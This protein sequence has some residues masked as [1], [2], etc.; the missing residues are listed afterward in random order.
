VSAAQTT[1]IESAIIDG[2]LIVVDENGDTDF[3]A[4]ESYVAY[5]ITSLC[6][7]SKRPH[8]SGN[9]FTNPISKFDEIDRGRLSSPLHQLA[10][11]VSVSILVGTTILLF[12]P[13][14]ERRA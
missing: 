10:R 2:E 7:D 4:L 11:V 6:A 14:G 12:I 5:S 9:D 1:H 13:H 3:A 8:S